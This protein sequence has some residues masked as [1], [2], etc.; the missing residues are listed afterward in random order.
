[1]LELLL[2]PLVAGLVFTGIHAWFGLH[3][4]ARGVVFV[5]LAL[6]QVAALGS[7]WGVL[8]GWDLATDP[9]QVK[10]FSLAFT[11]IGAAV[12]ALTRMKSERVPHEAL[13]GITYAVA[14]GLTILASAH[15]AHGAE[16]LSKTVRPAPRRHRHRLRLDRGGSLGSL[17]R[18]IYLI[19]I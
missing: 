4:L 11:F 8:L 5:D 15:L 17:D 9:W 3:V 12:F 18:L 10:A 6:A 2:W 19:L 7:V 1:M 13:I 14:L 16:D